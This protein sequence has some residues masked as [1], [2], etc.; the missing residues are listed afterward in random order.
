[1]RDDAIGK[2]V[3]GLG[4]VG[5]LHGLSAIATLGLVWLS[6]AAWGWLALIA[7]LSFAA[8]ITGGLLISGV[9]ITKTRQTLRRDVTGNRGG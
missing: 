5:P 3:N 6:V 2:S 4:W 8:A 7:S 9:V 1:M